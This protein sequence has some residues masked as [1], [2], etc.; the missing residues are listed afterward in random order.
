[1]ND[2][3]ISCLH[4][5]AVREVISSCSTVVVVVVA[6]SILSFSLLSS[7]SFYFVIS[8][9]HLNMAMLMCV[10]LHACMFVL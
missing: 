1:M 8:N 6:T 2:R 4:M 5:I 7:S 3:D 9:L 10:R